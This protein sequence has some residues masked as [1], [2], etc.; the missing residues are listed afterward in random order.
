[1]NQKHLLRFI[2][3]KIKDNGDEVVCLD[4]NRQQMTLNQVFDEMKLTAYD[5]TVDML[6]VHAVTFH[7]I[8][9]ILKVPSKYPPR[10]PQ[11][12]SKNPPRILQESSKNPLKGLNCTD[13]TDDETQAS[14]LIC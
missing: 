5:L 12:S 14:E 9:S 2:K 3:K 13:W 7:H 4:R 1:M 11:K 10:I 6:D 8:Q